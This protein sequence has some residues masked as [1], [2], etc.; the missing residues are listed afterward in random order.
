[1]RLLTHNSLRS[2]MKGV[3]AGLLLEA[4]RVEVVETDVNES[5]VKH[6]AESLDWPA[7]RQASMQVGMAG[8]GLPEALTEE[9]LAD[10]AFLEALHRVLLDA[11]VVEG[12]LVCPQTGRRF[13]ITAGIPNLIVTEEEVA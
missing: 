5:F 11:H 1:M 3:D 7:L 13:P 8:D 2:P 6:I 9:L 12:A 4:T 10:S